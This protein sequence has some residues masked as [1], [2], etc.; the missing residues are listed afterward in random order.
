LKSVPRDLAAGA[1]VVSLVLLAFSPW[2][3]G[4]RLFAPLDVLHELYAPW[5][6]GVA[7]PEVHNHFTSDAITQYLVYQQLADRS[8]AE[9][10][11]VGW[12]DL[13]GGG[14]PE[15]ANTMALYGDWTMQLHRVFGFWTA[16]HLGLM[17]QLIIAGL[18]MLVFLRSQGM[19]RGIGVVGAIAYAANTQFVLWAYHRW[20]LGAFAWV[21]WLAWAILTHGPGPQG[22]GRRRTWILAPAFLALALLGGNLQTNVFTLVVVLALWL[23]TGRAHTRQ[24]LA[25]TALGLGLAAFALLPD[26]LAL[27][28]TTGVSRGRVGLGYPDGPLQALWSALF[29]PLQAFPS[30]LGTPRSMDLT[31]VLALELSA[32]AFFG[33]LPT[34]V[35][36]RAAF[37]RQAPAAARWL[38]ALGLLI[39]LTPLAGLLYHRVQLLFVFGGVW[40]FAWYWENAREDVALRRLPYA[41]A[42]LLGLWLAASVATVVLEPRLTE[43]LQAAVRARIAGAGAGEAG[44]AYPH[45]M[46]ERATRLLPELRI[47]HPR[48]LAVVLA[49]VGSLVALRRRGQRGADLLVGAAVT[50]ELAAFAA[51]WVTF[52]D[53]VRYPPYPLT[54]ELAALRERVGDGRVFVQDS[55]RTFFPT[56]TLAMYGIA[57]IQE[58]ESVEVKGMWQQA[59]HPSDAASLARAGVTHT[60]SRP[61][62]RPGPGWTPDYEGRGFVLWKNDHPAPRYAAEG[63]GGVTLVSST[64]NRRQLE[65]APS[66]SRIRVAENWSEGW[67]FRVAAGAWQPVQRATDGSM[68]LPL[69]PSGEPPGEPSGD[70]AE[71][72]LVV[73]MEYAPARRVLGLWISGAALL[74]TLTVAMT[75]AF[76]GR[77]RRRPERG[78]AATVATVAILFATL[79]PAT[80]LLPV[81]GAAQATPYVPPLDPAYRDLDALVATGLVRGLVLGQRPYS[82]MTFARA[83]SEAR[84][85]IEEDG[86]VPSPRVREALQRLEAGFAAE[87]ALLC[88]SGGEACPRAEAY[89]HV[90]RAG[91]DLAAA[92]A[93]ARAIPTSYAPGREYLDAD[94]SPFLQSAQGRAMAPEGWTLGAEGV[95][96]FA[97]GKRVAGQLQPRAWASSGD[98]GGRADATLLDAYLRAVFGNLSLD[99]GRNHAPHGHARVYGP[100][101]SNNPRALDMVR[102][103]MEE[104]RRLPWVLRGLGPVRAAVW[105]ADMGQEQDT[106]GSKLFVVEAAWHPHHDLELGGALLNRQFGKGAPEATFMEHLRDL[107]FLERRPFLPFTPNPEISD[108]VLA[109]DARLGLPS[110]GAQLY[111]EGMT[112]DDHNLFSDIREGLWGNAAW[113]GGLDVSGLGGDGRIDVWLEATRA[114]AR[115]Y[116][117]HQ[118]TSGMA[119]DRRIM[120]TPLGPLGT[121]V[122]GGLVWNGPTETLELGAA[123]ER[124]SG[125][126]YEEEPEWHTFPRVADNPDEIRVRTTLD[127]IRQPA[128]PGLRTTVRLGY[129]HV[130]RFDF[131]ERSR[132]DF[133]AQVG[134]GWGW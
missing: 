81:P 26:A 97:L 86:H 64:F 54:P 13:T 113:T 24:F 22:E 122:Q 29:I 66:T 96:D 87:H 75:R 128:V 11:F 55:S 15:Y 31:K 63:G 99:V 102:L 74:A 80:L 52:A 8:Y 82:R 108:K 100:V 9:D 51:G 46:L 85:R 27:L 131:T 127:W 10:G 49:L 67:R 69:A 95:L 76:A 28:E 59:G 89:A 7:E 72:P 62:V 111:V 78:L 120:G 114:G 79:L 38:I 70:L 58:Y 44:N 65:V 40:A 47:W 115:A 117:H 121:G 106:P 103:T 12:S 30:L 112:T 88:A 20:Q 57:T 53:P 73:D 61:G 107:L 92:E 98:D 110:L 132:S 42:A 16:W 4:H 48:Q 130:T 104:P 32:I 126:A 134:V 36:Y 125:D 90:R 56:N 25:W 3:V 41:V 2:W 34:L 1:V 71:G 116:T 133:I 94:V 118:F 105:A 17:A 37:M 6:E 21:P 60:L 77:R 91:V 101:V 119:L 43:M 109:V 35:A 123:W 45:W 18:G 124:Y 39:P 83:V 93:P 23:G 50:I 19:S 68:L 129:E 14:R 5:N 33:F 84:G